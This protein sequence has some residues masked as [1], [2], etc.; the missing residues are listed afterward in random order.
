MGAGGKVGRNQSL[1]H[2]QIKVSRFPNEFRPRL[3]V[4]HILRTALWALQTVVFHVR[5]PWLD[6]IPGH[7]LVYKWGVLLCALFLKGCNYK[8]TIG[9]G[10]S[11]IVL[12]C[13][14]P[15]LML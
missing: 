6:P 12:N 9:A 7:L 11:E 10:H 4:N 3:Q 2:R 14:N 15:Q 5:S 1:S 13:H 8:T